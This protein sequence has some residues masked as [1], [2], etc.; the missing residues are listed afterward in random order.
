MEQH[1]YRQLLRLVNEPEIYA[2][3]Q[4]YMESRR[5]RLMR[6]LEH[7]NDMDTVRRVQGA[8]AELGRISTLRDEVIEGAKNG[9][10]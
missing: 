6:Q 1:V 3:L 7:A 2:A 5:E 4:T 10:A 8:L 9:K